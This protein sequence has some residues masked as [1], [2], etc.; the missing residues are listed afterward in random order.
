MIGVT[1]TLP[2]CGVEQKKTSTERLTPPTRSFWR[3]RLR[4]LGDFCGLTNGIHVR[5]ERH[6]LRECADGARHHRERFIVVFE[7]GERNAIGPECDEEHEVHASLHDCGLAEVHEVRD[8]NADPGLLEQFACS[9]R[10]ERFAALNES[11]RQGPV[12]D[13]RCDGALNKN[14]GRANAENGD[15]DRLGREPF[16]VA[17]DAAKR[18][19]ADGQ[20]FAAAAVQRDLRGEMKELVNGG[21]F[22]R[23]VHLN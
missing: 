6:V 13:L 17:V 20:R 4:A 22:C 11:A 10:S 3:R 2:L 8:G 14:D 16:F 15:R 12:A 1:G 23:H 9:G 18:R 21:V 19:P 7:R 5:G